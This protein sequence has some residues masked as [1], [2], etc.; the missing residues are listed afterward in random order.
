MATFSFNEDDKVDVTKA[1]AW[2]ISYRLGNDGNC[3]IISPKLGWLRITHKDKADLS[4]L[5][6]MGINVPPYHEEKH[7]VRGESDF[8][9]FVNNTIYQKVCE[10]F[11]RNKHK[12]K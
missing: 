7:W 6:E 9:F 5:K 12:E 8:G 10:D 3:S 1:I 11:Q 4:C 2:H